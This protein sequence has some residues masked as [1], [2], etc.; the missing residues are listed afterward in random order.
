MAVYATVVSFFISFSLFAGNGTR[1]FF[2][3]PPT[4]LFFSTHNG[5]KVVRRPSEQSDVTFVESGL[6]LGDLY[7]TEVLLLGLLLWVESPVDVGSGVF[8]QLH[9]CFLL[10]RVKYLIYV[11]FER[12]LHAIRLSRKGH[13]SHR[14]SLAVKAAVICSFSF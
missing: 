14:V 8:R 4:F 6:L 7:F 1:S 13:S 2:K 3:S 12:L 5:L 11:E 9:L 10:A